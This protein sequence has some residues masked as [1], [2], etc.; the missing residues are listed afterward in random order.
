MKYQDVKSALDSAFLNTSNF[1]L[2]VDYL[3]QTLRLWI[4]NTRQIKERINTYKRQRVHSLVWWGFADYARQ[5]CEEE[6][7]PLL[8]LDKEKYYASPNQLKRYLKEYGYTPET[9]FGELVKH[10]EN[11]RANYPN[12]I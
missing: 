5:R 10:Y 1:T 12:A 6:H 3:E 9:A 4:D 2:N 11:V 8:G 7:W